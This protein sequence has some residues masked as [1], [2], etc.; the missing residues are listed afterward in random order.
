MQAAIELLTSR[1]DQLRRN[2][3]EDEAVLDRQ[4]QAIQMLRRDLDNRRLRL[5]DYEAAL[6]LL[7]AS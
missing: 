2:L 3:A 1:R 4:E 5:A 6:A 7:G